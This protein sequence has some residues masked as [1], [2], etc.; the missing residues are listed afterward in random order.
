MA[1]SGRNARADDCPVRVP[2]LKEMLARAEQKHRE[3]EEHVR[4]LNTAF[5]QTQEQRQTPR[6]EQEHK[7]QRQRRWQP[8]P[9]HTVRA[10]YSLG[11]GFQSAG[12]RSGGKGK[13]GGASGKSSSAPQM[14]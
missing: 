13:R 5:L 2:S 11:Q 3:D 12:N 4:A 9:M 6:T 7:R 1:R 8:D 10:R 14:V